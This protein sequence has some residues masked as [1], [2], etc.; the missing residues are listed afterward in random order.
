MI[1]QLKKF[2]TGTI[3]KKIQQVYVPSTCIMQNHILSNINLKKLNM[4]DIQVLD[5]QLQDISF[6]LDTNKKISNQDSF[7]TTSTVNLI[8]ETY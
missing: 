8:K 4:C 6:Y 3:P 5:L 7:S 2:L 1:K